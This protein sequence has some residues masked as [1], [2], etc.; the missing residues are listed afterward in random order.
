MK[1][2][3]TTNYKYQIVEDYSLPVKIYP[4]FDIFEPSINDNRIPFLKL[5]RNGVLTIFAGYAWDGPSG[6]TIDT[7]NFMR[8]SLVHDALYQL[9]RQNRISLEYRK[10]ADELLKKICLEDGMSS[11]RAAYV[12]KAV[13]VFGE[14][15]AKPSDK[16]EQQEK[17]LEAP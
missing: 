13:R 16:T 6:T 17:I 3:E 14:S 9:M 10:Y 15:S 8:G 12:Y 1:Y 7:K 2:K 5:S 4:K 11:F